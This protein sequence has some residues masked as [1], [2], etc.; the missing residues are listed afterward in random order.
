LLRNI[1]RIGFDIREVHQDLEEE[2]N[3]SEFFDRILLQP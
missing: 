3:S 1:K 2:E